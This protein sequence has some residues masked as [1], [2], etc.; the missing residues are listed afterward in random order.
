MGLPESV[1]WME[2][3]DHFRQC[4]RVAHAD[5][6]TDTSGRS[7]GCAI[8]EFERPEEALKAITHLNNSQ[9]QG[10]EIHVREDREDRAVGGRYR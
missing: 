10:A 8:V 6:L 9:L 5:V 7:K 1:N 3:K 4:G 2:L